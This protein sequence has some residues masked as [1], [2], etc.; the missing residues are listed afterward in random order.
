MSA[1]RNLPILIVAV[2][3]ASSLVGCAS[4]E[5]GRSLPRARPIADGQFWVFDPSHSNQVILPQ[6]PRVVYA[7]VSVRCVMMCTPCLQVPVPALVQL[8]Q[9]LA[10][11]SNRRHVV[12]VA[13]TERR[14][15]VRAMSEP[16]EVLPAAEAAVSKQTDECDSLRYTSAWPQL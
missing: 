2:A 12:T 16:A 6:S 13:A 1:D 5:N 11:M 10:V 8:R 9:V 15:H 14:Y 3:F 7:S 4:V